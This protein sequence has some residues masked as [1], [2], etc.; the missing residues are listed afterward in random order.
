MG[1]LSSPDLS[2][3]DQKSDLGQALGPILESRA[4]KSGDDE[5]PHV[6]ISMYNIS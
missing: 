5:N 2:A 1:F 4:D 6:I 3:L